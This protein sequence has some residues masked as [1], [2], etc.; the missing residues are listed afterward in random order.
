MKLNIKDK[1]SSKDIELSKAMITI[2]DDLIIIE[3][4]LDGTDEEI[5]NKINRN[6]LFVNEQLGIKKTNKITQRK[7]SPLPSD[8]SVFKKPRKLKEYSVEES[9]Q[10]EREFK[11]KNLLPEIK[12]K[13]HNIKMENKSNSIKKDIGVFNKY[14]YLAKRDG[15]PNYLNKQNKSLTVKKENNMLQSPRENRSSYTDNTQKNRINKI[16]EM[17]MTDD[18]DKIMEVELEYDYETT[19]NYNFEILKKREKQLEKINRRVL[20]NIQEND[21]IYSKKLGDMEFTLE[22]NQTK[23]RALIKVKLV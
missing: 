20:Q 21:Q 9:L 16:E 13:Y 12:S 4:E 6:I 15:S 18:E 11:S 23:L 10:K 3:S 19:N 8:K 7:K 5:L 22:H 2:S 17:A 14:E 1:I